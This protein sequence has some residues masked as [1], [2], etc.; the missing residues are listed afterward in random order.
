MATLIRE[1]E[2]IE[3]LHDEFGFTY[4]DLAAAVNTSESNL[5]RWRSGSGAAPTPVFLARLAALDAFLA[6]LHRTFRDDTEARSW[7]DERVT[8]LQGETPRTM[9]VRGHVDRITGVLYAF[10]AGVAT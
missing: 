5:H 3:R 7:L 2:A 4:S 1:L 10:N 9:I 6:E 8:A